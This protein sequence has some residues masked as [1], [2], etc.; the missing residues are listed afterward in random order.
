M[1]GGRPSHP[2][3]NFNRA[4]AWRSA[5]RI[6]V[7]ARVG[8]LEIS[9]ASTCPVTRAAGDIALATQEIAP[10]PYPATKP[11]PANA[12]TGSAMVVSQPSCPQLHVK[13]PSSARFSQ[14]GEQNRSFSEIRH[15]H[16][17]CAHLRWLICMLVSV[18]EGSVY[19]ALVEWSLTKAP[20]GRFDVDRVCSRV[21]AVS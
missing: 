6:F 15:L 8:T 12:T 21:E 18:R 2:V 11:A 1:E 17:L 9:F 3:I 19:A 13:S 14:Y 7:A 20:R 4:D 16:A 5:T 10:Q